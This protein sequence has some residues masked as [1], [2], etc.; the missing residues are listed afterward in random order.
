MKMINYILA[1][2]N[3]LDF[4]GSKV[5]SLDIIHSMEGLWHRM[6]IRCITAGIYP[7]N[8]SFTRDVLGKGRVC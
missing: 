6:N 4:A 3:L 2:L 1:T 8:N 7:Y 5:Y